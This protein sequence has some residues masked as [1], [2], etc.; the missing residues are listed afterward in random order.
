MFG[1]FD[2]KELDSFAQT[3]VADIAKRI[4]PAEM[5]TPQKNSPHK[6]SRALEDLYRRVVQYNTEHPLGIYKKAKL[7]N[8][9]RWELKS[10]GYD[11]ALVEHIVKNVV[12][13]L[14]K[15]KTK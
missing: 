12:M 2:T 10:L 8:T 11:P 5:H 6:L 9:L 1:I 7:G 3:L 4:P 14:S 15:K 13:H